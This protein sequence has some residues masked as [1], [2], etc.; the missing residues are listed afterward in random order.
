MNSNPILISSK[1]KTLYLLPVFLLLTTFSFAQYDQLEPTEELTDKSFV[2]KDY[3]N[4]LFAKLL[5]GFSENSVARYIVIPS[6]SIE[7]AFSLEEDS[8]GFTLKAGQCKTSYWYSNKKD[9][10]KVISTNLPIDKDLGALIKKLFSVVVNN[11]KKPD[12]L[13]GG[14]D[15]TTYYF[16]IHSKDG[17]YITGKKWSPKKGTIMFD[18]VQLCGD[19]MYF[20]NQENGLIK[21]PQKRIELKD[22]I[23]Q[24]K[25]LL[26]RLAP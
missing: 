20:S 4:G 13:T 15:G 26:N 3:Y 11:T 22:L 2:L 16:S 12:P 14:L 18:L 21:K 25:M 10:V 9:S 24:T 8:S 17:N 6:F 23:S 7:Y 19:L 5:K 1:M